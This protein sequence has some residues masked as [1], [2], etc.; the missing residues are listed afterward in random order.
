MTRNT[1][2]TYKKV[3]ALFQKPN[4]FTSSSNPS[5]EEVENL[6]QRAEDFI[7]F[8]TKHAWRERTVKEEYHD[9]NA[10]YSPYNGYPFYLSHSN[11]KDFSS[12]KGDKIEVW[13]GN[14][15]VDYVVDK[16]EG[17]NQDYWLKNREGI[18]YLREGVGWSITKDLIKVTYRF[19]G[20]NTLIDDADGISDSD[21]TITVDST[22]DFSSEGWIRIEDE[23]ISY[24]G[25]TSSTFT[26]CTRGINETTAV[27]HD[28]NV[29]VLTVPS[30][31]EE[32]ATKLV[33]V[34]VLNSYRQT[35]IIPDEANVG[36][37]IVEII[38]DWRIQA[39][40]II[41]HRTSLRLGGRSD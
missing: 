40:N 11:V 27:S 39:E 3:A 23:E 22:S 31:I 2:T 8:K 24:T 13:N 33:A 41:Y 1:Y 37:P 5:I 10:Y 36:K 26:G 34:E 18:L 6:I 21:T 17:R 19:G 38:K 4:V 20:I 28:D 16:T 15:Y 30:D 25:K 12:S 32:A 7:D 9:L 14:S 29:K 35:M